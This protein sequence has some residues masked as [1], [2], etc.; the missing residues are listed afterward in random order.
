MKIKG[1]FLCKRKIPIFKQCFR[2]SQCS[3]Y[4]TNSVWVK[5]YNFNKS[6]DVFNIIGI[7]RKTLRGII[8][9][10]NVGEYGIE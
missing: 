3:Y 2:E 5:I 6:N 4:S 8:Y 10:S 1:K 7:L 9:K